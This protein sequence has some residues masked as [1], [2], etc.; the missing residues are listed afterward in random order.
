MITVDDQKDIAA[1]KDYTSPDKAA[2]T[3]TKE[4]PAKVVLLYINISYVQY[5]VFHATSWVLH[6][7]CSS[8]RLS[9]LLCRQVPL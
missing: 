5:Y 6:S 8:A 9:S 4:A 7:V 1:F 3:T 2:A